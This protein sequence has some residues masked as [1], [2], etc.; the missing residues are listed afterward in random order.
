MFEFFHYAPAVLQI[1]FL[2]GLLVTIGGLLI[3]VFERRRL[4]AVDQAIKE[5]EDLTDEFA[6]LIEAGFSRQERLLLSAFA[7]QLPPAPPVIPG[8]EQ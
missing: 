3:W 8:R 4:D 6:G 2:S 7:R 5:A 1:V